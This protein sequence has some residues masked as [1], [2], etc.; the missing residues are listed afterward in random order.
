MENNLTNKN[1]KKWFNPR[2]L[3]ETI[4]NSK[5]FKK[6]STNIQNNCRI[7]FAIERQIDKEAIVEYNLNQAKNTSPET[8]KGKKKKILTAC[9]FILNI[10]LVV[11][12]FYNFAKEQGG[13]QPFSTLIANHPRWSF[14]FIALGLFILTTLFNGM[15]FLFLIHNKTKKWRPWFSYKLGVHGRYYDLIT[16]LG[17]GGQPFEIYYLKK[18]GYSG[19]IS[20]AIPLAKYMIWQV[21]TVFLCLIVLI[22]YS[23]HYVDSPIVLILAWIGLSINLALF[24]FVFFMSITKKWGASLVV[25]VLKLLYKMKIIKNYRKVLTKVLKFVKSYQLCIK[26]VVKSPGTLIGTIVSTLASTLCN[27]AIAYFVLA[28]FTEN[29]GMNLLDI[30]CTCQICEMAVSFVPLPGGSGATE[31]S[32]NALLGALFPSGTL[33]WGILIWRILTYYMYIIEG[34]ILFGWDFIAKKHN[35]SKNLNTNNQIASTEQKQ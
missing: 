35:K 27:S 18:D 3:K 2:F 7:F 28:S 13:I 24:L 17:T 26:Q 14:L 20:T 23:H 21:S 16:P 29:P 10:L 1:I 32:F 30:I 6:I 9:L 8:K 33:F 34:W 15:K 22:A 25:G 12:V 4:Q 19:D 31:L 11:L 5:I